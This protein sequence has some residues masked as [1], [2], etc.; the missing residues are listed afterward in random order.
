MQH[1][2]EFV[3]LVEAA[4]PR[5][6]EISVEEVAAR[7]ARGEPVRLLDVREDDEWRAGHAAGAEHLGKGVI[8]RDIVFRVPDKDAELIL[9]C[10]GGYRS[11]LA[12]DAIGRMGYRR[13][14]SMRGGW[15]AWL[16]AGLPTEI[17]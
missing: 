8:E 9:Y 3:A 4:R 16:A 14:R 6:A 5:V 7:R 17:P 15:K 12:A 2:P 10:G 13:V 1:S 11:V